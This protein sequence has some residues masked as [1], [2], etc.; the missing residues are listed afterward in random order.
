VSSDNGIYILATKG[1]F[2]TEYRVTHAQAIENIRWHPDESGFNKLSLWE[3]FK[4]SKVYNEEEAWDVARKIYEDIMNNH[5]LP[6]IEYGICQI[7]ATHIE[8]PNYN[9]EY[10]P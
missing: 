7:N 9:E 8:F 2:F 6:I 5:D 10:R 3:Y 1:P 4:D